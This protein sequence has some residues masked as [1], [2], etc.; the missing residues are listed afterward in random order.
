MLIE[1]KEGFGRRPDWHWKAYPAAG[2]EVVDSFSVSHSDGFALDEW[3][4]KVVT[5]DFVRGEVSA[6]QLPDGTV[7]QTSDV[8]LGAAV[9]GA[10][11]GGMVIGA[12]LLI[13]GWLFSRI[14]QGAGFGLRVLGGVVVGLAFFARMAASWWLLPLVLIVYVVGAGA[15]TALWERFKQ[16]P[17][18]R[19]ART[20]PPIA[21]EG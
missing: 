9:G 6:V 3:N 7:I 2:G 21:E 10:G 16:A 17:S 5:A 11:V 20:D 14:K 4:G 8:G 15:V 19:Q 13:A 1:G 12:V 18:A